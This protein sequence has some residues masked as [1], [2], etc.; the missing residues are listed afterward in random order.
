MNNSVVEV[1]LQLAS[2]FSPQGGP[3]IEPAT[4]LEDLEMESLDA[5]EFQMQI[6]ETYSIELP[7]D[8]FSPSSTLRDVIDMISKSLPGR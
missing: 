6:D 2:K 7:L 8:I 5:L 3:P 1:I 4:R